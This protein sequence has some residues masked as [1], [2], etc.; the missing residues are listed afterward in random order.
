MHSKFQEQLRFVAF[1][2]TLALASCSITRTID[3]LPECEIRE[4]YVLD[5]P[6]VMMEGFRVELERQL[7]ERGLTT[8]VYTDAPPAECRYRLEYTANW[9]WDMAMY[10]SY[11]EL[12]V[13]DHSERIGRAIYDS[14]RGGGRMDKFGSTAD[15]L[16][17]VIEPLF[18]SVNPRAQPQE[19]PAPAP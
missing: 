4:I 5:N 7:A 16:A 14:R 3:P 15:K 17:S 6:E 12:R 18:A 2:S 13:Y 9:K 11:I 19:T 10:V 8:H 1:A